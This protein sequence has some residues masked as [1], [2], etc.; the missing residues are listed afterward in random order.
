MNTALPV[1]VVGSA[2][3][4]HI[5][6]VPR[7]PEVGETVT[8]GVYL[9]TF[10]G[11]GANAAVGAARAGGQV[12]FA[13]CVGED[14]GGRALE[15]ELRGFGVRTRLMTRLA[16]CHSGQAVVLVGAS[17]QNYLAVAP[18]ANFAF[19]PEHVERLAPSF[20][21]GAWV[22]IQNE[23]PEETNLAL[24]AAVR[25]RRGRIL[26]NFAPARP[27]P[28]DALRGIDLLVVNENEAAALLGRR[29]DSLGDPEGAARDLAGLGP[30]HVVI[31]LGA[32][33]LAIAGAGLRL[34]L[35]ARRVHAV[36]TT[37]AGDIFCG[38]LAVGLSE[39]L[40]LP[41]AA[42]FATAAASISVTRPGSMVSAPSRAE[43]EA[44]LAEMPAIGSASNP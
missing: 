42:R 35:P 34:R 44:V 20:P 32:D 25:A 5:L 30:V 17:G 15:T 13:G 10:G 1:F 24:I 26:F 39:G 40:G 31:T 28:M 19:R 36:D 27:F 6:R 23:I 38:A 37:A 41:G 12:E 9:P 11:K 33:G 7:L 8:D 29:A 2:N 4:D 18:G 16:G 21:E 43:I 3:V 22:L 14:A